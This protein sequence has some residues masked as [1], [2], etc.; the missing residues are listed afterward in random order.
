MID[1][2]LREYLEAMEQRFKQHVEAVETR[3]L[4]EFHKWASPMDA[5]V[6]SHTAALRALDLEVE[7]L[8]D[9]VKHLEDGA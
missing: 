1:P 7:T 9:R 8:G 4:T 2:D 5:R 6:R 3:L